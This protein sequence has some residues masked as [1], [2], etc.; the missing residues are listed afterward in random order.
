L[1]QCTDDYCDPSLGCINTYISCD[2]KDET[3]EDYCDR[4]AGCLH[5]PI[6]TGEGY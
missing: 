3:T 4:T 1:N 2:D 6:P 5:K